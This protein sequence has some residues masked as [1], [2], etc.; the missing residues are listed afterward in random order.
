MSAADGINLAILRRAKALIEAL[1][2]HSFD[3]LRNRQ[4]AQAVEQRDATTLRD[5]AVLQE[6]GWVE[7]I[8]GREEFWRLSPRL[9]QLAIAHQA[10]RARVD[11]RV[12]DF[13]NRYSRTPT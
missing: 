8:P 6:I 3:G 7:R 4:L 11:Q 9:I 10:E 2:G 13:H 1:A 5:L 12:S